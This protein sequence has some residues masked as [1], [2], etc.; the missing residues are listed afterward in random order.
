MMFKVAI[1]LDQQNLWIK[2]HLSGFELSRQNYEISI[3]ENLEDVFDFDIVFILGYTK[4]I[5]LKQL[6]KNKLNLIIH[7]SALPQDRGFSPIQWQV[8]Q[9]K[10]EIVV[11]L[12]E[13]V[14]ALDEGDIFEQT[15]LKLNGSELFPE[16]RQKQ[17]EATLQLMNKF[18]FSFPK[19]TR[20][21]QHTGGT[22]NRRLQDSDHELDINKSINENFNILRIGD[23]EKWPTYFWRDGKK[24]ILKIYE[25]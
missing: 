6:K 22:F 4:K 24:F 7:E 14:E 13:A 25:A 18:L 5:H 11:S 8:L 21:K 16:L 2:P 1:L 10:N 23:N 17:A 12:I 9:G 20:K 3:H 15:L 19:I